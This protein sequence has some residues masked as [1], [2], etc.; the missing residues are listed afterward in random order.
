MSGSLVFF[1]MPAD[2]VE[3]AKQFWGELFAWQFEAWP[4]EFEYHVAATEPG[5]GLYPGN[6]AP[7]GI[8]AYFGVDDLDV[9]LERVKALGGTAADDVR[10]VPGVGRY[11]ACTDTEGNA[12][13]L[14]E[15]EPRPA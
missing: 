8:T 11:A 14:Y 7:K 3:R 5:G 10:A 1:D 13:S 6:G 12:F 9:A 4:G 15:P 2:D